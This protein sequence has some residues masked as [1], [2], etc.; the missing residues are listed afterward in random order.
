MDI[1]KHNY[2]TVNRRQWYTKWIW[3]ELDM[4]RMLIW[5]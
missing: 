5:S 4:L 3:L 2:T 1:N